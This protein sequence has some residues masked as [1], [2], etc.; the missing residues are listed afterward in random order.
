MKVKNMMIRIGVVSLFSI[1][2]WRLILYLN[3]MFSG[4]EYSSTIHFFT[5]LAITILCLI[6]VSI[7][8]RMDKISWKQIAMSSLRTNI[9]SFFVGTMLWVIPA[10]IGLVICLLL[11]WAEITVTT[12]LNQLLLSI[13]ILYITVFLIEAFPEELIMRGY[14]Y[15]HVN[16]IFPHLKTLIIQTLIFSLFAYFVGAIYSLEQ[17]LFIPGYGFMLGYIRAKSGNVWTAIGFHTVIMTAS[18]IINP[19]HGHFNINGIFAIRFF[20]F[21]LLPYILGAIA[22]EYIYPKYNWNAIVPINNS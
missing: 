16:A 9:I 17:L 7:V 15:S 22:L 11:G 21:N 3:G 8:L 12:N 6:L 20:A 13:L 10:V 2:I 4:D 14:I 18:Q 5:A 19:M 1:L